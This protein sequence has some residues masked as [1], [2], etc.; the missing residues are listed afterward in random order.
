MSGRDFARWALAL[1]YAVAGALHLILPRPFVSIVPDWVPAPELVVALTGLA[2][3]AGAV[4]LVQSRSPALRRAAGWGLAAYALCVWPA[5]F[6]HMLLDLA[7]PG[8]GLGLAYHVPRLAAQPLLIW[9][10]LWASG[11]IQR[12]GSH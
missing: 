1:F 5:N 4:G 8:H 11:A 10:A 12:S 6:N 2:E 9:L 7:R 3:I